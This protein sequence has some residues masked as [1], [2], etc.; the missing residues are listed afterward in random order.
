MAFARALYERFGQLIYEFAKFGVIGVTGLFITNAVYGLLFIHLGVGPVTSTTIATI[1]AAVATYLGNRYWSFRARQR[2]GV[3][4]E[5]IVFAVLNAIGVLIQDA[6]VAFNYYVLQFGHNKLAGFVA[7]NS[8][9]ALA[10]LFR[11]WSYRRFVW[12]AP[13]ADAAE[14]R[15]PAMA[16]GPPATKSAPSS[17][18]GSSRQS[19]RRA[20]ECAAMP[21]GQGH[22]HI[23]TVVVPRH[24]RA[25]LSRSQQGR[26]DPA[27]SLTRTARWHTSQLHDRSPV[28]PGRTALLLAAWPTALWTMVRH[29]GSVSRRSGRAGE[30]LPPGPADRRVLSGC[31]DPPAGRRHRWW[32]FWRSPPGQPAW[33]R[34]VLAGIAA[35]AA[36]LYARNLPDAGFAFYYSTAVKSMSVS[37]KAFFY[38]AFDPAATITIDKLA[39][40]LV[41]QALS[42]RV[43]GF[44]AWS[45]AL[46]QVVEGVVAVL[47]MYRVVRRWAGV[48]AGLLAAGIFAFTPVA[49]SM[50]GHSMED[51]ALTLC[52]V[53]AADSWQRA[54][55]GARLRSLVWAGVWVGLGFQAKMLQ[56][57]MIL[58]A[59][60]V[61]Y[62][63]A[64]PA[65]L[66]AR[67]WHLGVAGA[68]TLAVSL[69]WIA[70]YTFTPAGSRPYVD[71]TT[72]NSAIAMVFGYN[73]LERFNV[74]VPGA[75]TLG[76][77][78][79]IPPSTGNWAG[80][81]YQ[82]FGSGFGPQISWLFPLAL[83]A[84]AAGLAVCHR[85]GRADPVRAGFV[86]WGIWLATFAVVFSTMSIVAHTAYVASL[87]PPVAALSGAGLVM[88]GRWYRAGH[89]LGLLLPLAVAAELAW[90]NHLW[91]GYPGFL[92]WA[93][94]AVIVVGAA[95]AVTLAVTWPRW[96]AARARHE[97]VVAG[98]LVTGVAVMLAAPA[99]WALSVLDPAYA[100]GSF[101]AIA[102]PAVGGNPY[103]ITATLSGPER[104]IYTY[105]SAH[106]NGASYLM[107][108]QSWLQAS[109]Y[110]LATGQE[111]LPVGG[112]TGQALHP[113]P[114]RIQQLVKSGQLRFVQLVGGWLTG[115]EAVKITSWVKKACRM[116][117]A[118]NYRDA[119][120]ASARPSPAGRRT[121]ALYQCGRGS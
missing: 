24:A 53:L 8:G 20:G 62:L 38:G 4:R 107:A 84:L 15:R 65:R 16:S 75:I 17:R 79:M 41:P 64:A 1:V 80:N 85:A 70:L 10:T 33:A 74:A 73:G 13:L 50:F 93:R 21:S 61:G 100:G 59:L 109:P 47:V 89:R 120:A 58:P 82:L 52:L 105:V 18:E 97:A 115:P 71:G 11:F 7:L 54:V 118:T 32:L 26:V 34:P 5:L 19:W 106:R 9:I 12:V 60:A 39:G 104:R 99:I 119:P 87:A 43:F 76:P 25:F 116:I 46:P 113:T 95:S 37:W 27:R 68:V 31:P 102:G 48:A 63:L 3:V 77:G 36:V 72:N 14:H 103:H 29:A 91:S 92:P 111:V 35:A 121:V 66:R 49:A 88:F 90:A 6:A 42:A 110:I 114:A 2:T 83:L 101:N 30:D 98:G 22:S 67:L 40:A 56:A 78:V 28:A 55:T 81:A 51:G 112:F 57:W 117:P 96:R 94:W 23:G 108:V 86:M 45:L 69:S 44:H